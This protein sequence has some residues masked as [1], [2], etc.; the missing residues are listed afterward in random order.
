METLGIGF[1]PVLPEAAIEA[2]AP[3]G[4]VIVKT[5]VNAHARA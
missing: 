1:T 4:G 5:A 3:P 2:A